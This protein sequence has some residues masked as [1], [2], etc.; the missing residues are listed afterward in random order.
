MNE[1]LKRKFFDAIIDTRRET[2]LKVVNEALDEGYSPESVLFN[3]LIPTMEDLAEVIRVGHDATLAQ[4]YLASQISAELTEFL[5]PLFTRPVE[6]K[7]T[8]VIGTA[9]EDFHGLGK[10]IVI[11]CLKSRMLN[12]IDLGLNV[13]PEAFIETAQKEQAEII[14]VSSMMVHTARGPGG[15]L[16]IRELIN[17][18]PLKGRVKLIVGGAPYRFHAQLYREVGAD[19]WAENGLAAV[20]VI[21]DMIKELKTV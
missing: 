12:V 17:E 15:P 6:V 8:V 11:G 14:G 21:L 2:A 5:T 4:L 7:G 1:V 16:K 19:G 9:R 13:A 20:Q 3:L 18:S 10:K